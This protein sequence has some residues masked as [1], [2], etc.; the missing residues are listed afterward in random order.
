[1]ILIVTPQ[2]QSPGGVLQK[3]C[4]EE[5]CQVHKDTPVTGSLLHNFPDLPPQL[6]FSRTPSGGCFYDLIL[7][8]RQVLIHTKKLQRFYFQNFF[9]SKIYF[10]K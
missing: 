8:T 2:K 3:S 4:A 1:M 6:I 5:L 9:L 7:H 10:I